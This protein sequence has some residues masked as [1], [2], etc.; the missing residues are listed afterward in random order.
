LCTIKDVTYID[1]HKST[2][3]KYFLEAGAAGFAIVAF[4]TGLMSKVVLKPVNTLISASES[5]ASGNFKERVKVR[6]KDEIGVLGKQFNIMAEEV[7][8]RIEE[9]KEET[10]RKQRFIDN[11]THEMRTPLTSIIGYSDLMMNIKYDEATFRK[12]LGFIKSEGQRML[13]MVTSL[14]EMILV[15]E[16]KIEKKNHDIMYLLKEVFE[17]MTIKAEKKQVRLD[18][19]G[20]NFSAAFDYDLLK[21]A[22]INLVDNAINACSPQDSVT[23]GSGEVESRPYIFI[24]DTGRGISSEELTRITEPFYRVDKSRSRKEGGAGLGLSIC[25][26]ILRKHGARLEIESEIGKGTMVKIIF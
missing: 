26:E 17:V 14:M 15:R 16:N 12:S 1:D 3:Y 4:F 19:E 25:S 24:R 22:V 11:L 21:G 6:T 10:E 18:I 20:G 7:E 2:L 13:K 5:I 9:L 8:N 23:L